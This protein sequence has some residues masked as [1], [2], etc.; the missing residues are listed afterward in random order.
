MG[1]AI[2]TDDKPV[3]SIPLRSFEIRS[4]KLIVGVCVSCFCIGVGVGVSVIINSF[5][6]SKFELCTEYPVDMSSDAD[7]NDNDASVVHVCKC[8]GVLRGEEE[9]DAC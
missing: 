1:G 3:V 2:T 6:T 7:G 8:D 9:N 5:W 4:V